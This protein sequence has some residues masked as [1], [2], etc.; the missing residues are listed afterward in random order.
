VVDSAGGAPVQRDATRRKSGRS[1]SSVPISPG[2]R[3]DVPDRPADPG[4]PSD[5]RRRGPPVPTRPGWQCVGYAGD[6]W[7]HTGSDRCRHGYTSA[8]PRPATAP[9]NVYH[10]EDHL[11]TAL[12]HLLTHS[13][14]TS[15]AV[16]E[17]AQPDPVSV[18]HQRGLQI[19]CTHHDQHLKPTT[20]HENVNL[21]GQAAMTLECNSAN[22]STG[23][24]T[25]ENGYHHAA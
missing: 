1:L 17:S 16:G 2:R 5:Q 8:T 6:G 25:A 15:G 22:R 12:P 13:D 4:Q 23:R 11:L 9:R 21:P 14:T 18:L 24:P 10:R 3:R 19:I 7:T 20:P